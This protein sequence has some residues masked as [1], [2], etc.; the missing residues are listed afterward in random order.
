MIEI[1]NNWTLV[2]LLFEFY[3]QIG[4]NH[5]HLNFDKQPIAIKTMRNLFEAI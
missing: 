4:L 2:T 5:S 3:K 1:K